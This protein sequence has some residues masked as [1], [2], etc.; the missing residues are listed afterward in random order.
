MSLKSSGSIFGESTGAH[1]QPLAARLRPRT[2]TEIIG[3][4]RYLCSEGLIGA[5]VLSKKLSSL[6]LA[7][8]PGVGKTTIA[9]VLAS[10]T[11]YRFVPLVA[12]S[13]GVKE[14]KDAA[15]EAERAYQIQGAK[16]ALF[17]DEIHRLT[18]V[19]SDALLLPVEEGTFTLI[20]ATTENPWMEVIPSLLSRLLVVE[21]STL[22]REAVAEMLHRAVKLSGCTLTADAEEVIYE[23][24]GG[25]LRSVMNT[26]EAALVVAGLRAHLERVEITEADVRAVKKTASNGLS[27]SDHYEMTSALIKSM[28]ASD[29]N[30][31]LYWLARLLVSGED[32]RFI[33]R[34]LLIFAS[35]DVGLA[36]SAALGVAHATIHAA[37]RLGMP[38]AR[39][40]LGHCVCYLSLA[41]KSKASYEALER[42]LQVAQRTMGWPV[43]Q[44][45]RGSI[46]AVEV[47]RGKI[48]A[49]SESTSR[50]PKGLAQLEFFKA[51]NSEQDFNAD[52][53][54]FR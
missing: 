12:T 43:P 42:A 41:P 19:Q 21:L 15:G 13:L 33:A 54:G 34:R 48:V 10:E 50:F 24:C 7:G 45:L 36:D 38:E 2:I 37:E 16:T 20:G 18:K 4:E 31:A 17:I 30:A 32:P 53:R 6:L 29:V 25:D 14:I 1:D 8:P 35:E 51:D 9:H 46:G 22:G 27:R 26:F 52:E 5:M 40:N 39:I 11:S 28:R 47:S 3:H 49:E 23:L 44:H